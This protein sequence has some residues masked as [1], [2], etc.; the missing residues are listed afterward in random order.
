MLK[1]SLVPADCAL[2][3]GS[4]EHHGQQVSLGS[5]GSGVRPGPGPDP[6]DQPPQQPVEEPPGRKA[7]LP[8]IGHRALAFLPHIWKQGVKSQAESRNSANR[9]VV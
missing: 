6:H 3:L 4:E 8:F 1:P 5:E 7:L 9:D 2:R